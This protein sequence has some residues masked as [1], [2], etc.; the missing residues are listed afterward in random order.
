MLQAKFVSMLNKVQLSDN[1]DALKEKTDFT[2]LQ[3]ERLSF[4]VAFKYIHSSGYFEYPPLSVKT[5]VKTDLPFKFFKTDLTP[6]RIAA[7][8][9]RSD[10]DYITKYPAL[11]PD[12]LIELKNDTGCVFTHGTNAIVFTIELPKDI[13]PG[14]YPIEINLHHRCYDV[15]ETNT[16]ISATVEVK[17]CVIKEHSLLFT[18]WFHSD[19]LATY[20]NVKP[21]S[22]RHWEIIENFVK[23]AAHTGMN[24]NI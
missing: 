14:K 19:C 20:Y 13:A 7:S 10:D 17:P 21:L 24:M 11:L 2:V 4:Q 18:N 6:V 12:E 1:Y 8:I 23:A 22:E 5:T 16:T 15:E 3:G 9:D